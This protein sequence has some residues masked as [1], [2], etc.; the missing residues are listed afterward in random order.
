VKKKFVLK[1]KRVIFRYRQ[2]LIQ[3]A[4]YLDAELEVGWMTRTIRV[5]QATFLP[6][7]AGLINEKNYPDDSDRSCEINSIVFSQATGLH[8]EVAWSNLACELPSISIYLF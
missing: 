2:L 5:I 4:L 6:G 8:K 3:V 1:I 7:Q